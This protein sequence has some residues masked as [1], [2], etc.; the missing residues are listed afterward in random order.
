M[1]RYSRFDKQAIEL[2]RGTI[3]EE[4]EHVNED[5][6]ETTMENVY[7]NMFREH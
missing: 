3:T 1:L 2:E 4:L 5:F 6:L 7:F